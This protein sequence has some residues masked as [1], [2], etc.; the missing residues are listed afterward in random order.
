VNISHRF[1][2]EILIISYSDDTPKGKDKEPKVGYV[3]VGPQARLVCAG[4]QGQK[5]EEEKQQYDDRIQAA[6]D[7]LRSEFI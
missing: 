7:K 5:I 3:R 4:D 1:N 2:A 6:V